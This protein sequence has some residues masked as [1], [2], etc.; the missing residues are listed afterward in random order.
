MAPT[1]SPLA[2]VARRSSGTNACG[3]SPFK[4][5][6]PRP[7]TC[8]DA[9]G[10]QTTDQ[11]LRFALF[12][13]VAT[14]GL[15]WRASDRGPAGAI[16]DLSLRAPLHPVSL[17]RTTPRRPD[18]FFD[19]NWR[20]RT[21]ASLFSLSTALSL[22]GAS[23]RSEPFALRAPPRVRGRSSSAVRAR[24][25]RRRRDRRVAGVRDA[26]PSVNDG[27]ASEDLN[28]VQAV[29]SRDAPRHQD[30]S[31]STRRG[32]IRDAKRAERFSQPEPGVASQSRCARS[33]SPISTWRPGKYSRQ[34]RVTVAAMSSRHADFLRDT[35]ACCSRR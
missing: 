21:A 20:R 19:S 23:P 3:D 26:S 27:C 7:R 1:V 33:A 30:S 8:P 4:E 18:H 22:P 29:Q 14:A 16:G 31:G 6:G 34:R 15:S 25:A 35:T 13:C 28:G 17:A 12:G 11:Y 5:K 2:P 9:A 32:P 24:H 10:R